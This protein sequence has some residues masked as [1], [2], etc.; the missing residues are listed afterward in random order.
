MQVLN[1]IKLAWLIYVRI[2]LI[3]WNICRNGELNLKGLKEKQQTAGLIWVSYKYNQWLHIKLQLK[4]KLR[5]PY[6]NCQI[7]TLN[8]CYIILS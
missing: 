3:S 7:N 4:V 8:D 1:P 6:E 5:D 2:G